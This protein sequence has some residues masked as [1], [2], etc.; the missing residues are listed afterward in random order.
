MYT[1]NMLRYYGVGCPL[2]R[3]QPPLLSSSSCGNVATKGVDQWELTPLQKAEPQRVKKWGSSGE[4]NDVYSKTA[5]WRPEPQGTLPSVQDRT[6][7]F[8]YLK[9]VP[10]LSHLRHCSLRQTQAG[11]C[12][13]L[14]LAKERTAQGA[15]AC[16]TNLTSV[17][18]CL[19]V[20][21][22]IFLLSGCK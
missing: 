1:R 18:T 20:C 22:D 11:F 21:S 14:G 6:T 16:L 4:L 10:C 15:E 2:T 7:S 19:R 13:M 3:S 12:L 9:T 5:A 8:I 17:A